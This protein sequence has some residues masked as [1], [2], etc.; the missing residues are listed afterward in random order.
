MSDRSIRSIV[1]VSRGSMRQSL[2]ALRRDLRGPASPSTP[3]SAPV[4]LY[5]LAVTR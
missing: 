1:K 2:Q 3:V 4:Y 5:T